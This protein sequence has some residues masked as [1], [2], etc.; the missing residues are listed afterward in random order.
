MSEVPKHLT[1]LAPSPLPPID[2]AQRAEAR[3]N[4][5]RGITY[6]DPNQPADGPLSS[7]NAFGWRNVDADGNFTGDDHRNPEI[8]PHPDTVKRMITCKLDML[9]WR[10][11]NGFV[12]VID[13]VHALYKHTLNVK[14]DPRGGDE[15]LLTRAGD[16]TELD[17]WSAGMWIPEDCKHVVGVAG[18]DVIEILGRGAEL[19]LC[20]NRD[21]GPALRVS[22]QL[23]S[24]AADA[25]ALDAIERTTKLA[26]V[27]AEF[28][29]TGTIG[30]Q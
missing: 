8:V 4:P 27:P 15:L 6:Y 1:Y 14:G 3:A 26:P 23:L 16:T 18:A 19:T 7:M 30:A 21:G 24:E 9:L 22:A 17:V 5:G 29:T 10:L 13:L 20:F 11:A 12:P 25:A 28:T 2:D